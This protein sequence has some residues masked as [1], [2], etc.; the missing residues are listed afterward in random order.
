MAGKPMD[1]PQIMAMRGDGLDASPALAAREQ[2]AHCGVVDLHP[3]SRPPLRSPAGLTAT[4]LGE[5]A[6]GIALRGSRVA[7]VVRTLEQ[8]VIPRLVAAHRQATTPASIDRAPSAV[9]TEADV[10]T[11]TALALRG[12]QPDIEAYADALQ[13]RG[14]A[15]ERIYLELLAPVAR[16]LGEMWESDECDFATVTM[17]LCALQQTVLHLGRHLSWHR[18]GPAMARRVALS[19]VPGEQHTLGLLIVTEFFRRGG[20]E[21]WSGSGESAQAIVAKV[22]AEHFA[23]AGFTLGR[24]DEVKLLARLIRNVRR[25]SLNRGIGILVGGP[26]FLARPDLALESG[27]DAMAVDGEQAVLQAETLLALH[28]TAA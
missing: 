11:V 1:A 28:G 16:R 3:A 12:D 8:D 20:W 7:L 19:P 2:A 18:R 22:G 23:I 25:A 4:R 17:G 5:P 21:V 26:I 6:A 27:A 14:V 24:E 9:P 13:A 15:L 10:S